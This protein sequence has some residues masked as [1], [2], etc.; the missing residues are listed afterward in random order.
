M[1]VTF[2]AKGE[3]RS[4]ATLQ[5]ERLADAEEAAWTKAFWRER[6]AVLKELLER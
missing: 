6:L 2:E 3:A 4:V 5:H 1:A